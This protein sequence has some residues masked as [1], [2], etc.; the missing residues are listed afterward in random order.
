MKKGT[1]V[2]DIFKLTLS[3]IYSVV[4]AIVRPVGPLNLAAGSEPSAYPDEP[5]SHDT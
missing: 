4:P 3:A 1:L 2:N 5:V